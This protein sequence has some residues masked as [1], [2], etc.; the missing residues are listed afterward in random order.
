MELCEYISL[1]DYI[2]SNKDTLSE[3]PAKIIIDEVNKAI[4]YMHGIAVSHRDLKPENILINPENPH[5]IK[6]IDFGSSK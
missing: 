6:I 3:V 5:E 2:K 1:E 4:K